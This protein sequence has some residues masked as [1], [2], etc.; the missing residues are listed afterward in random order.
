MLDNADKT[1]HTEKD[2]LVK[3]D[4]QWISKKFKHGN[5]VKERPAPFFRKSHYVKGKMKNANLYICGLGYNEVYINGKKVG[6]A[7]LA[8]PF[9]CYD[10]TLIYSE[11]DVSSYL[12]EGENIFGVILGNGMYNI[13]QENAWKFDTA[14]WRHHPKMI[15]QVE[16][17]YDDGDKEL[18]LSDE[19]WKISSGPITY[20]SL[21]DGKIYDARLEL[22]GWNDVGYDDSDWEYASICRGSGGVLKPMQM[23]PCRVIE[24]I[25]PKSFWKVKPNV[26]VYDMGKNI[27][28][29]ARINISGNEGEIVNLKYAEILDKNKDIDQSNIDIHIKSD[30]FQMD[31]Y[32]LKGEGIE[33]WE[34]RFTYHGFQYIQISGYAGKLDID[35]ISGC[36]VHTDLK[37][38]G[39]FECSNPLLNAIQAAT[40]LSTLSNYH[41]LPT[42][43]PHREK[44]GWTG[45][46][47]LSAEQ[48]ILNF[49]P[50]NAYHK[51][52]NDIVD[53]QRPNGQ[54]PGIVPTGGWGYNGGS[55]PAWDSA[56]IL[57]PWYLYLY[58][59][60][61]T[62][63]MTMYEPMRKYLHFM[64]TMS[65]EYTVE[66]GLGDWC[67]PEGEWGDSKCPTIVTDTAYFFNAAVVL[68]KVALISGHNKNAAEYDKLANNIFDAFNSKFVDS[69]TGVVLGDCQ[70]SYACALYFN[71]VKGDTKDKVISKLIEQVE[72]YNRHID[73][74]I[75]GTKYILKVLTQIGRADLAYA[76]AT[77]TDF[78][79]W[80]Y[81][82]E[83]GATTL[84]ETWKG[85]DSRNHHM[86]GDISAWFYRDLAGIDIDESNPGYKH[87][88]VRPN[89]VEGIDWV[90]AYH[91]SR[92]GRIA[93]EWKVEENI[94]T[95][96][97]SIP[98]DTLAKV[99][100]PKEFSNDILLDNVDL[101]L[102]DQ[103]EKV[104]LL[105][106]KVVFE[107]TPGD[108][109]IVGSF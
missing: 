48:T 23:E 90:C 15:I 55:G 19:T 14:P 68:N 69:D 71:L 42:D 65:K 84:W 34:P 82:I 32:I 51:W 106:E 45:D 75:L 87:I 7:V 25:K 95:L 38:S 26:W 49:D 60:D 109:T 70:T 64:T 80:G 50:Q 100:M 44:N 81:F 22:N 67:P 4:A 31:S 3:W 46:A 37:S 89:P 47:T 53:A 61:T 30:R 86:F 101:L 85:N 9:T 94:F 72:K 62:I 93:S 36:R 99:Y 96:K 104:I 74:G 33:T 66:Y 13:S 11:Y 28:G 76:I 58:Y 27:T 73:C 98:K 91:D 108:Y 16:I 107:V 8:P 92:Y 105:R 79:G 20:D 24:V 12:T 18:L 35:S 41:G 63:L 102:N 97:I 21:Y 103:A 54:I 29:W 2:D 83:Q 5:A 56:I 1:K 10:K 78:P 40:R 77:Q 17:L 59:G 39:K 57:I 43:C 52:L 88:I 6:D